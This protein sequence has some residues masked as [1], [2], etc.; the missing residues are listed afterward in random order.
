M[1]L[2]RYKFREFRIKKIVTSGNRGFAG[3]QPPATHPPPA[4]IRSPEENSPAKHHLR[5][6]PHSS[7]LAISSG[8]GLL[9]R[10]TAPKKI[11]TSDQRG[12]AGVRP[13]T[14][15]PPPAN[16]RSPE[17]NSPAQHQFRRAPHSSELAISYGKGL[18]CRRTTPKKIITS[19]Q[20]GFAELQP[21]ATIPPPAN[22]RSQELRYPAQ[23][24]L[25]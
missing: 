6:A 11:I 1:P 16:I 4:N 12:F 23:Y 24:Q 5:R 2:P 20:R 8:K 15:H 9:C 3:V 10:R 14:K 21:P 13:T 19:D 25:R 7:E 18:F 22:I 17:L